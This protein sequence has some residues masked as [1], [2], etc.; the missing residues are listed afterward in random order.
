[1]LERFGVNNKV[2]VVESFELELVSVR[3]V[4]MGLP[5]EDTK[6]VP[7]ALVV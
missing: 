4:A 5:F 7:G 3:V 1:V 2:L 6:P